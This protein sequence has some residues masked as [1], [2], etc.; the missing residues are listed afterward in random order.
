MNF[1]PG[2]L[3]AELAEPLDDK[4]S[5]ELVKLVNANIKPPSQL[6]PEDL[7]IRAM[8]IASDQVNSFGGRFP[9]DEMETLARLLIDSPVMVGHRKD[10]L[11]IGRNFH[12]VI[13]SRGESTWVKGYFYWLKG[14]ADAERLKENIDG[15]IY[16]ECSIGFT[17]KFA[18]CSICHR[19]IRSCSHQPLK[20][21]PDAGGQVREC[22]FEYRQIEK[23]LETS[24]VYRGA[25]PNTSITKD[26]SVRQISA[27]HDSSSAH[28][29][30]HPFELSCLS[31]LDFDQ[32]YLVVPC[33]SS[34][35]VLVVND[36][37]HPKVVRL[38]GEEIDASFLQQ[39]TLAAIPKTEPQFGWL[40]GYRGKERCL[41][42]QLERRLQRLSSSVTRI[43]LKLFPGS[44]ITNSVDHSESDN[45]S[46]GLVPYRMATHAQL[47]AV[48]RSIQTRDGVVIWPLE[49]PAP[50]FAGF[51]YRLEASGREAA[52]WYR[53][54][55]DE[56]SPDAL[57]ELSHDG[58]RENFVIA[59]LA[60]DKRSERTR[61]VAHRVE[62]GLMA[63]TG[64]SRE[65]MTG[66]INR[67]ERH[68][69]ALE[70]QLSGDWPVRINMR[71]AL[72][73][74]R[75]CLLLSY[76]VTQIN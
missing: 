55:L 59:G 19:D 16:K 38:T 23:V 11:P 6:R 75:D 25:Q 53:L 71:P 21:Y 62:V 12:A 46:S 64:E 32:R 73:N 45:L 17:F 4:P 51:H 31:E 65:T 74:G 44:Q 1:I 42:V 7:Y 50:H 56:S 48:A 10:R 61:Y 40:I 70:L 66:R 13:E 24:L 35:P 69:A 20:S 30:D 28:R 41:A 47:E 3:T 34:I 37:G 43:E 33:Y 15:G 54:V 63:D 60:A 49:H 2:R 57:L 5:V 68:E 8:Y 67:I 39:A 18:R 29:V 14:S 72:L 36:D 26:L 22:C 58:L 9:R 76:R 52:G 27:S